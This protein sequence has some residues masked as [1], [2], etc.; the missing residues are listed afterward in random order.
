MTTPSAIKRDTVG[1]RL[2]RLRRRT[3]PSRALAHYVARAYL[4]RF[5]LMLV[6]LVVILQML[7]MLNRSDDIMAADGAT[8]ASLIRYILW[9]SPELI[10][11]FTPFA[12]L[13]GGLFTLSSLN[14]H[15]EVTIMRASGLSPGQI[16]TPMVGVSLI[17]SA[18]H[19]VFHDQVTVKASARL[20]YWQSQDYSLSAGLPPEGRQDL[21]FQDDRQIVEA[22]TATRMGGQVLLDDLYIYERGTDSLLNRS[23]AA[24]FALF[25]G[26]VWTL[27]NI[28]RFDLDAH[29]MLS[30]ETEPWTFGVPIDHIF[31]QIDRPEQ[32]DIASLNLAIGILDAAGLES[33]TLKTSLYHRFALALSSAIMP[34]LAAFVA[35]GLPRGGA[36][37][38][39]VIL[40]MALGF[41]F[42]VLDNYMV[43]MGTMGVI[44]PLLSAY[45]SLLL[46]GLIGTSILIRLD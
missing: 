12:A 36:R 39:R 23:M 19:A 16:I 5:A 40:G 25:D 30:A 34:L 18:A 13:L 32:A 29:D 17:I 28:R 27:Y 26:S 33:F 38:G 20:A 6:V 21:W 7:D 1:G 11:Q 2:R 37:I 15:S 31:A 8:R 45:G 35:F 43:A 4:S 44:P 22:R 42:F 41:S 10:S 24:E 9:R 3:I 14:V 46:Y